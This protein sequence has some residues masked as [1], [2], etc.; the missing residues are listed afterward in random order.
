MPRPTL[1][2]DR[3][4][5]RASKGDRRALA[6]IFKRYHQDLYRYCAAILGNSEDARDALQNTMVK[7]LGTLPGERRRIQLK[8]WLYRI[9]HNEAIEIL[10]KRRQVDPLEPEALPSPSGLD[11]SVEARERLRQLI[12][13]LRVLPER[14]RGALVMRELGGLSFEQIGAA[15]DTSPAAARQTVYEARLGLQEM[16]SG[17]EMECEAVRRRLSDGDRRVHRR[18]DVRAHLRQCASC[19][20]FEAA[21]GSRRHDL[22]AIAPLPALAAAGLLK[23]LLGGLGGTAAAAGI[24]AG[25]GAVGGTIVGST[26]AKTVAVVAVAGAIGVSAA[27]RADLIRVLPDSGRAS[28]PSQAAGEG[29]RALRPDAVGIEAPA[30]EGLDAAVGQGERAGVRRASVRVSP[31]LAERDGERR[32]AADEAA[33]DPKGPGSQGKAAAAGG[34]SAGRGA[35]PKHAK[36][37]GRSGSQSPNAHRANRHPQPGRGTGASQR[38]GRHFGQ[39]KAHG[40]SGKAQGHPKG[41]P[42]PPPAKKESKSPGKQGTVA[43]D[44]PSHAEA[45]PGSPAGGEAKQGGDNKP[46]P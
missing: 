14:Q 13:D 8:P 31:G 12:A 41:S 32:G 43:S 5:E 15:F 16:E 9:A 40:H 7:L 19:R 21:M 26:A 3:L 27:D 25:S 34:P 1:A 6:A 18:R 22:A 46:E 2:D 42:A 33:E 29:G 20:E 10:R 38:G 23:S 37:A 11:S 44:G 45:G 39:S 4:V 28:E 17:R 35:A 24:G 30:R 36:A